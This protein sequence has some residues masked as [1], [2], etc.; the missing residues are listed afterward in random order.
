MEIR[1]HDWITA[2]DHGDI[3][4]VFR[5]TFQSTKTVKHARLEITAL[6]VYEAVLNGK[7]VGDYVLAPG[8]TSYQHRLQVQDYDITALLDG[9][10]ELRVTVG[11]GWFRS[12][13]PGWYGSED[14]ERRHAQPCGLIAG[15]HLE[16]A[17][18]TEEDFGTDAQWEWAESPVRF[19]ELYDGEHYDATVIPE[20]WEPAARLGWLKARLDTRFGTISAAWFCQEDG[21]RYELETPVRTQVRL[22]GK[23]Q[24]LE[25]GRYTF[26]RCK[27][28]C[29]CKA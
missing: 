26:W 22:N 5:R 28:L 10:N 18:G 3:C 21:I 14:K 12:P 20:N 7:R 13:L 9:Q 24:T 25:K 23:I 19:S 8:W 17:D 15:I 6:G 1:I 2:P 11:R 16:Y 27:P 29:H 4:L